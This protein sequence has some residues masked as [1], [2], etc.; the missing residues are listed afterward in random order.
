MTR[1]AVLLVAVFS[2]VSASGFMEIRL[3]SLHRQEATITVNREGSNTTVIEV[4]LG[5][6]AGIARKLGAFPIDFDSTYTLSIVGG[7]VEQL[8]INQSSHIASFQPIRGTLSPEHLH[9]PLN[10]LELI[11]EC[12]GNWSGPKCDVAC[13]NDCNSERQNGN[14]TIETDY[15]VDTTKLPELVKRLKEATKVDNEMRPVEEKNTKPKDTKKS[16]IHDLLNSIFALKD[17]ITKKSSI[18]DPPVSIDVKIDR[19]FGDSSESKLGSFMPMDPMSILKSITANR[20]GEVDSSEEIE[21]HSSAQKSFGF[22]HQKPP[23]RFSS[24]E[25]PGGGMGG[26][27]LGPLPLFGSLMNLHNRAVKHSTL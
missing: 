11:F 4:P 18:D 24:W 16:I 20:R 23:T 10:G 5:L 12:E 14:L 26:M 13:G 15:T 8:G 9:L 17:H 19:D 7:R 6:Q 2:Y 3:Q 25:G 22:R 1:L 27:G 21:K